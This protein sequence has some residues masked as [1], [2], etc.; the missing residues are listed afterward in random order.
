MT[1]PFYPVP[2]GANAETDT[3]FETHNDD[4]PLAQGD[5]TVYVSVTDSDADTSSNGIDS[6]DAST[7]SLEIIRGSEEAPV[8]IT[9][10]TISETEPDSGVF[11]LEMSI[12]YNDGPT[13]DCP[14]GL[15][16]CILQ[17]DIL[18]VVYA[19]QSD[20]SGSENTVTDSATFDLRNGVLQSDQTAYIIGKRRD[21]NAHRTRLEP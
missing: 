19:D 1:G 6:I 7:V 4:K 5:L 13:D 17:G 10:S 14:A 21:N 9:D 18:H 16:G 11:E 8:V 12:A 3:I 2:F 15:S 20:A